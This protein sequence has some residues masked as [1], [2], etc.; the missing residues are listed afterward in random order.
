MI[1][2]G[3]AAEVATLDERDREAAL[4]HVIRDGQTVDA[5][6]NDEH[7]EGLVGEPI[8]IALHPQ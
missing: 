4:R 8:E 3:A 7:V 1:E 6:A 5:A 2:R